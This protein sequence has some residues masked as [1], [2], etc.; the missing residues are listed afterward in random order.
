MNCVV[1]FELLIVKPGKWQSSFGRSYL[2]AQRFG[3]DVTLRDLQENP[4]LIQNYG[5]R[6]GSQ[7]YATVVGL[8]TQVSIRGSF[9]S[10][11]LES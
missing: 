4:D 8:S 10:G 9:R 11:I 2:V 5:L 6:E 3:G 1:K 7:A